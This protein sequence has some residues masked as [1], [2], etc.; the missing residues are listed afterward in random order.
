VGKSVTWILVW[1]LAAQ[2]TI[3]TNQLVWSSGQQVPALVQA[4]TQANPQTRTLL[5]RSLPSYGNSQNYSATVITGDGIHLENLSSSYRYSLAKLTQQNPS[6]RQLS[7]LTAN[8]ISANGSDVNTGLKA[9]GINYILV[10]NQPGLNTSTTTADL[11][12]S[13]D[14]VQELE[15]VGVTEY[16]RLWRVTQKITPVSVEGSSWSITKAGQVIVLAL[17][18]LLALPTRRRAKRFGG[19]DDL[20]PENDLFEEEATV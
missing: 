4:Q 6:Y 15:S 20:A 8:L 16:G 10:L 19:N 9:A 11:A 18:A 14:T 5:L 2:F 17:F 1:V 3:S 13:L 12:A 7:Q